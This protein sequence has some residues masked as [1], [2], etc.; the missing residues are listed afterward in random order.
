MI[1]G[2][3][4]FMSAEEMLEFETAISAVLKQTLDFW[5]ATRIQGSSASMV[6]D[7]NI[8]LSLVRAMDECFDFGRHG[9][10]DK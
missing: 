10:T 4:G 7:R 8:S 1:Y 3:N 2:E 6:S 5:R 9:L